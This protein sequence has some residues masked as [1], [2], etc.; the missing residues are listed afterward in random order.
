MNSA[1]NFTE[2]Q[3]SDLENLE[4]FTIT[5]SVMEI[6][7]MV[8]IKRFCNGT[9]DTVEGYIAEIW[10]ILQQFLKFKTVFIDATPEYTRSSDGSE[11]LPGILEDLWL[12]RAD[13]GLVNFGITSERQKVADFSVSIDFDSSKLLMYAGNEFRPIDWTLFLQTFSWEVWLCVVAIWIVCST[14]LA[15]VTRSESPKSSC[16]YVFFLFGAVT[17]QGCERVPKRMQ[18]RLIFL[19]Y[20][21]MCVVLYASFTALLTTQLT[22]ANHKPL[23]TLKEALDHGYHISVAKGTMQHES[24]VKSEHEEFRRVISIMNENPELL[25]PTIAEGIERTYN[26]KTLFLYD[27]SVLRFKTFENCSFTILKPSFFSGYLHL[28]YRKN[29]PYREI[30]DNRI[31]RLMSTGILQKLSNKWLYRDNAGC[32]ARAEDKSPSL[33]L[34]K[35]LFAFVLIIGGMILSLLILFCEIVIRKSIP[36]E[37]KREVSDSSPM[38]W[39]Y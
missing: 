28:A 29:F 3:V 37:H 7:P 10:L 31:L 30:L 12:K 32:E 5:V 39:V 15:Y 38:P 9:I 22:T 20:W 35:T 17:M 1:K 11:T 25:A 8:S 27:S 24:I 23:A 14:C 34:N 18:G 21:M 2:Y 13:I 16:D 4:G 6:P 26:R 33:S 19:S 36:L